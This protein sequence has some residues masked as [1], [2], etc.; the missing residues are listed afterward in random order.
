MGVD[1]EGAFFLNFRNTADVGARVK[2]AL[3]PYQDEVFEEARRSAAPRESFEARAA[4]A[5]ERALCGERGDQ[6]TPQAAGRIKTIVR[7]DLAALRRGWAESGELCE[8][9]GLGQI[10]AAAARELLADSFIAG[11]ITDGADP[12]LVANFGRGATAI[13]QT[14]L[15]FTQPSC[16]NVACGRTLFLQNDH[17]DD[18]AHILRTFYEDLDRLCDHCHDLKTHHG[19]RLKPGT[20][21]RRFLSPEQQTLEGWNLD[22]PGD[23]PAA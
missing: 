14:A 12:K 3:E 17:R 6:T 21:K 10:P 16:D 7:V 1:D 9:A 22:P 5:L 11:I 18:W 4:D 20:G 13:Q 23:P 15:E 19:W 8:I 2:A